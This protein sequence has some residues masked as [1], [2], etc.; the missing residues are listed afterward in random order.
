[1]PRNPLVQLERVH[2]SYEPSKLVLRDISL[3]ARG[4]ET[5]GFIGSNGAG[6]TT[7]G[8]LLCGLLRP[9]KGRV[10]LAGEDAAN[11]SRRHI[12]AFASFV[13]QNP[14]DQIFKP[15]VL[16][17]VMVGPLL[18]G[19]TRSEAHTR[20]S[21]C[22]EEMGLSAHSERSPYDLDLWQRKLLGI[23]TA[24]AMNPKLL[25]LDEPTLGQDRSFR[26]LLTKQLQTWRISEMTV[27]LISHDTTL[28]AEVCDTVYVL[29]EG[30][31]VASGAPAKVFVTGGKL[32]EEVEL[33]A[34]TSLASCLGL[35]DSIVTADDFVAIWTKRH[36]FPS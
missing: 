1:M 19:K 29:Q 16:T 35:E 27:V 23:A 7:L 2:F 18:Q 11:L 25:V 3:V 15:T 9:A 36:R 4:G 5:I 32:P 13:F 10:F 30:R 28:L 20:A 12:A 33:P 24:L 8:K 26:Y 17:E 22:L 21:A 31:I 34:P 6:K 14:D